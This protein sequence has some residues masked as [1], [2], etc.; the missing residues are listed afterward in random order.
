MFLLLLLL[1]LQIK[2]FLIYDVVCN[3]YIPWMTFA[4]HY[5]PGNRRKFRNLR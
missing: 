2:T 4:L 1:L 5:D 3:E